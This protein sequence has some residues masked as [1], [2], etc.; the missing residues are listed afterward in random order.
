MFLEWENDSG[1][2]QII[3]G[4]FQ[5]DAINDVKQ[6]SRS[7]VINILISIRKGVALDLNIFF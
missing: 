2:L 7:H 1:K 5:N 6:I 4:K 3:S